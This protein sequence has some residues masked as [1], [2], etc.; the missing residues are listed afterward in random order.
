MMFNWPNK[1]F[2]Y[3]RFPAA[4][5]IILTS[6]IQRTVTS[7]ELLFS[8]S[9]SFLTIEIWMNR[10]KDMCVF[11]G[12]CNRIVDILLNVNKQVLVVRGYMGYPFMTL[13]VSNV[14]RPH[15]TVSMF[16]RSIVY[17]LMYRS[18]VQEFKGSISNFSL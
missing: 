15:V 7:R 14:G 18:M 17:Q 3:Q 16:N 5:D 4:S 10:T 2:F 1:A 13:Q 8:A 6:C 9:K 12:M 11:T